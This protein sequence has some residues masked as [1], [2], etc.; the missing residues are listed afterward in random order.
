MDNI[1][2]PISK[3]IANRILLLQA[4]HGDPL[5]RVSSD[6]PDDV[7]VLHDALEQLRNHKTGEPL[8][9]YLKNCGTALRFLQVHLEYCYKGEPIVLSGDPRLMERD[10]KPTTQTTSALIL[11]GEPIPVT[12]NESPYITL[13]RR[14]ASMYQPSLADSIESCWSSAA[15]WYEYVAIHGGELL[16]EGLRPDSLQGDRIVADLYARHFGVQTTFTPEGARIAKTPSLFSPPPEGRVRVGFTDCPDLYPAIALTCERLGI[17]LLATGTDRLRFKESDRL[18][19]VRLHEVRNDH[20]MAMALLAADFITLD[21]PSGSNSQAKNDLQNCIAKSYPKFTEIYHRITVESRRS[22]DGQ[23]TVKAYVTAQSVTHITPIRGVN[24]DHLGKKH[25]LSKLIHAATTEFVWLHDDDVILPPILQAQGAGL[26]TQWSN[27]VSGLTGEA[28][29]VILPLK[30]ETE[31]D[32]PSLLEKLQIAEYSAIQELTMRTAKAGHAVMCSG[33]NLIVRREAWLACEPD[34]HPEIPSGDDMFLL[35]AMKKRGYRI[36]VIDE[37]DFTAV[38]HP[39]PTWRAFFRQRMRWAGKA[40][41]YTDPDILRCGALIVAANLLQLL[42][43]LILLIKFPIEYSL[44]RQR[45]ISNHKSQMSIVKC[46]ISNK[47]PHTP[48]YVALLLELLYPFY[49]LFSLLGGLFRQ[50]KW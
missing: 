24:D 28:G 35:E 21:S 8:T 4:I 15:F 37:P 5:M 12:P 22:A 47:E 14:M 44:I 19:A 31:S 34:L 13:S 49:I 29:L 27:S 16:L 40:P 20:R 11:H 26:T 38:V 6:M 42:C 3:S 48:W 39:A 45:E 50:K 10:G 18:E 43:P 30:M 2:L 32:K 9:L 46:Q 41:K 23:P 17:E 25:A 7:L 36:T 33:A 1:K